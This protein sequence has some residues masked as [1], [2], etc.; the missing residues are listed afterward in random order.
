MNR[1]INISITGAESTYLVK[2]EKGALLSE[3]K[4]KFV[5][6]EPY[7]AY[8]KATVSAKTVAEYV[9]YVEIP[10]NGGEAV[11]VRALVPDSNA[12][13]S[14]G[15]TAVLKLELYGDESCAGPVLAEYI[16]ESWQRTR[17]W[18]FYLSQSMHTDIGYTNYQ[19]ELPALYTSFI[20]TV[21]KFISESDERD[22]DIEK[23]KYAIE[24]GWV[25]GDGYMKQADAEEIDE[26]RG[27]IEKGRMEIGA[28][29]FNY[30]MECFST[31]ELARA[32]YYTN[33]YLKDKLGIDASVTERMF[34]NPAFTKSYVDVA[35]S[36]GIRYGYHSMNGDRSP[37]W[38]KKE[39]DLFYLNGNVPG[40]RLLIF[41]SHT[42][43]ENY[44]FSGRDVNSCADTVE[45]KLE[46][47]INEL[48]SLKDRRLFPYDKFP[49]QLVPFGDN[50]QPDDMQIQTANEYNRRLA[51]KGYAYPRIKT[52]FP[53]EFF[54]D[55]EAEYGS[56]IPTEDGTEENWWNDG[57]GTT[58]YESGINK[59]AGNTIPA[60]ETAA[61]IAA[62][63]GKE[64]PYDSLREAM[65]RNL[66][67]DEHTW[68][69][70]SYDNS[71]M[72]HSQWEWKRSNA[73]GAKVLA[74]KALDESVRALAENAALAE[75]TADKTGENAEKSGEFTVFVYNGLNW[76]RD[77]VVKVKLSEDIPAAFSLKDGDEDVPYSVIGGELSFAAKNVPALGYKT[78]RL[79]KSDK[80]PAAPAKINGNTIENEFYKVVF[81]PDGTISSITDK[82]TGREIVDTEAEEKFNQYRYY[83]DHGIPFSNMGFP[84]DEDKWTLYTPE[85][86]SLTITRDDVC[87][88]AK[89]T[90]AAFRNPKIT[91]TVRLYYGIPRIDI[92]NE[93][94]KGRLPSLHRIEEGFYTFP[95]R[96][97]GK[98]EIRYDL[99]LGN[100]AEG[101]Q[102]YG[103]SHD[104][105]T[106]G[107]WT[108]VRDVETG[109]NMVLSSPNTALMQFGERRTGK[110]SF[111]YVSKKPYLYSYVFNNMWQTNFQGDQPGYA[112]FRYSISTNSGGDDMSENNRFGWETVT[113]LRAAVVS[114]EANGSGEYLKVESDHVQLTTM[115]PAEA[116][117][118]GMIL[119]FAEIGGKE[120]RGVRVTLPGRAEICETDII[121][122]DIGEN[123][124]SGDSFS[125]N[126]PAYGFK[127]YRIKY[128][129]ARPGKVEGVKIISTKRGGGKNSLIVSSEARASSAFDGG[130]LP[131]FAKYLLGG[132]EW[133]SA[134]ESN[135]WIEFSWNE[136]VTI[137]VMYLMSRQ[138]AADLVEKAEVFADDSE[139]PIAVF[140]GDPL[141]NDGTP[142]KIVLD[143]PVTVK[144]LKIQLTGSK[145]G[146]EGKNNG[147]C[148]F[149]A[150]EEDFR[151]EALRGT[152]LKW[153]SVSGAHFY[154][155][156]RGTEPDFTPGEGNY[157]GSTGSTGF[158]D[159][160]VFDGM[161]REYWYTV[162]AVGE[163]GL[164]GEF[165]DKVKPEPAEELCGAGITEKPELYAI[166]REE[167]RVDLYWTPIM[168][169][170]P[171]AYYKVYRGGEE[172]PLL[173]K[174]SNTVTH[175]DYID[176]PESGKAY[177]YTVAAVDFFGNETLSEPVE[178]I[179]R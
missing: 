131:E 103:T 148:G 150:Y 39:Y 32:A 83:D 147:L 15:E 16:D 138:N 171:V 67:Y 125:F 76:S 145:K 44:G 22:G 46:R 88:E 85:N 21:K 165:S 65:H 115:K 25:M 33:R 2:A 29:Q 134:G 60:A 20:D 164:T 1:E 172:R 160:Q 31:E 135:P 74:D 55:V 72:Y 40:N 52:A 79:V 117:G 118:E 57:W 120:A 152:Q 124:V 81:A 4:V 153:N 149:A 126:I 159:S 35:N 104:W 9:Q 86:V 111:D 109:C 41:N 127:T 169:E 38:K 174:N 7:H 106:V 119:R 43:G 8:L 167:K 93:V 3:V 84:F 58:A 114:G 121:E 175:R 95:F 158:Y 100:I 140:S 142:E 133:A 23:Y 78:Y 177:V 82:T 155:I 112:D 179:L 173:R 116:N 56:L 101:E 77:D 178:V 10:E 129:T 69:Y 136:P 28:G 12:M 5:C 108:G 13:L 11:E 128:N 89:M 34:D 137:K 97:D 157:I 102:V 143:K 99:P 24:S 163:N 53:S 92:V 14:P 18:E 17:H 105:Y 26:V 70:H 110:W 19:G 132:R 45:K 71:P 64:Y 63:V 94:V 87:E 50:K 73:F 161:K 166:V 162:R 91:Q 122:N 80:K 144:K 90:A 47:L 49:L 130:Y 51:D 62:A 48:V 59:L 6:G 107:K 96:T 176:S 151:E 154:R 123:S 170:L 27:L 139:T 36:A 98:H 66:V 156:Y 61:S 113:P 42:Y 30:T 37:Y 54:A 68:G 168:S 75:N 141:R 146:A